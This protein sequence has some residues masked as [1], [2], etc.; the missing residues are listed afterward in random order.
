MDIEGKKPSEAKWP[1]VVSV[2]ETK[3][4]EC[5]QGEGEQG[6]PGLTLNAATGMSVPGDLARMGR[7]VRR[8]HTWRD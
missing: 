3:R 4:R 1:V 8:A 2:L 7:G 6:G 5:W